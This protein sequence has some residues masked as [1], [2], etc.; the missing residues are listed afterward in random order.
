MYY[1]VILNNGADLKLTNL[2]I[3]AD[4][5]YHVW[6]GNGDKPKRFC[7]RLRMPKG[8]IV[9]IVCHYTIM[10]LVGFLVAKSVQFSG[11]KWPQ[12]LFW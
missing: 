1:P 8:V 5:G 6:N 4:A 11:P 2:I 12:G 7:R 9:G 3:P 10:P